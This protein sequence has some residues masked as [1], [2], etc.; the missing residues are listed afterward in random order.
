M[1]DCA[2]QH[3][4]VHYLTWDIGTETSLENSLTWEAFRK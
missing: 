1:L 2:S 4:S 3:C